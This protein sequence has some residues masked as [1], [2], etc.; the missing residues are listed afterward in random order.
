[1]KTFRSILAAVDLGRATRL[2]L[3]TAGKLARVGHAQLHVVHAVE[4]EAPS[5]AKHAATFRALLQQSEEALQD[6]LERVVTDTKPATIELIVY[7]EDKTIA[8]RARQVRADLIIIGAHGRERA[9]L[10]TT[11]DRVLRTATCPV[12][13]A[14]KALRLPIKRLVVTTDLSTAGQAALDAAAAILQTFGQAKGRTE[15][16]VLHVYHPALEP[17]LVERLRRKVEVQ[18]AGWVADNSLAEKV[19]V[20]THLA[21]SPHTA[22]AVVTH[23]WRRSAD[24]LVLGTHGRSAIDRLL[25]GSTAARILRDPP[26]NTLVVPPRHGD[27]PKLTW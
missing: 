12:W 6:A 19:S 16:T 14:R 3:D 24:L 1:M 13:I 4:L 17:V 9:L 18:A 8:Q 15:V 27:T 26:C 10:G 25:L 2:V 20:R 11:A 22:R 23:A 21:R 7:S 5:S